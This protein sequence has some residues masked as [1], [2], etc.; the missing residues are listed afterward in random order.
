MHY[1]GTSQVLF[2][3]PKT[4]ITKRNNLKYKLL[5]F[6]YFSIFPRIFPEKPIFTCIGE[7]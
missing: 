1:G 5:R 6:F 2:W 3:A 7:E 4:I